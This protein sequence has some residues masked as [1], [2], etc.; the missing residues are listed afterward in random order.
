MKILLTGANG[1]LGSILKEEFQ[2]DEIFT[3]GQSTNNN[4]HL[5]ITQPLPDLPYFDLVIHAAGKAHVV[6]KS[7][8][9]REEF[10][11]VNVKGT[12]H[13]LQ[14]LQKAP[15]KAF[16]LISSVAVYGVETGEN[17]DENHPL[18]AND[19]YGKSKC[20]SE[21]LVVGW[22]AKH[23]VI[24]TIFR[25][26]LVAGKNP[27]GNLGAMID[28]IKRNRYF[29]ISKGKTKR[30]IVLGADVAT[31]TKICYLI[32]GIFNL[33]DGRGI[34]YKS[35]S[36]KICKALNK[37]ASYNLPLWIALILAYI[38][39]TLGDRFPFNSKR[40]E[41]L[42]NSLTFSDDKARATFGWNPRSVLGDLNII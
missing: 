37:R 15:P 29:N 31:A 30:S 28:A 35:L 17:I 21:S 11:M 18:L 26:P 10:Y 33:T 12:E 32:G 9:E 40:L 34:T 24:S 13:L 25:L 6:P 36:D 8:K 41:K 3:L 2:Q 42:R 1:F 38:G 23:N 14:S 22:C 16:V 20:M 7:D 39:D 19:P 27:P 5:D 4:Y